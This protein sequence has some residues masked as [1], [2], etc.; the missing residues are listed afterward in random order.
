MIT[1]FWVEKQTGNG[2]LRCTPHMQPD[3][4]A[5]I[6]G[7]GIYKVLGREDGELVLLDEFHIADNWHQ[8]LVQCSQD[9][10]IPVPA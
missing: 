3:D 1:E 7:S 4:H 2:G 6:T 5:H 10:D 8:R 9:A